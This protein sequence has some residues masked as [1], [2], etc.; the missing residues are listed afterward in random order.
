MST[1]IKTFLVLIISSFYVLS[2]FPFG[3]YIILALTLILTFFYY[4]KTHTSLI[5]KSNYLEFGVF[6]FS[7]FCFV[8]SLWSWNVSN[9][10]ERS[11]TM[12]ELLVMIILLYPIISK[13]MSIDDVLSCQKWA[14]YLVVIITIL[15]FGFDRVVSSFSGETRL[16]GDFLNGNLLGMLAATS[17]VIALYEIIAKKYKISDFLVILCIIVIA[18]S[19]SRKAFISLLFGCLMILFTIK[20]DKKTTWLKRIG[21]VL[22]SIILISFLLSYLN[23]FSGLEDRLQSLLNLFFHHGLTD[24]SSITRQRLVEIG[25]AQFKETPMGGIGVGNTNYLAY[26]SLGKDYYLHNNYVELLASAGII[27][28]AI[29]YS[30]YIFLIVRLIKN[31]KKRTA[32]YYLIVILILTQLIM[33]LGYV[34]YYQKQTYFSFII[35]Y[36]YVSR[37]DSTVV[38]QLK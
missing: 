14:G 15:Y 27:G 13:S 36:I 29:Y 17:V 31:Y 35:Y 12:I 38:Q 33:D 23:V 8:S 6:L 37:L 21:A 25:L 2:S 28:F 19:E 22:I 30:L 18:G 20:T 5:I 24:H 3:S 26:S 11:I 34:S 16:D 9:T 4:N 10:I 7:V 1:T 32:M